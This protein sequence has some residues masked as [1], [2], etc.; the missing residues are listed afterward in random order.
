MYSG[1]LKRDLHVRL[2]GEIVDLVRLRLLHNADEIGRIGGIAVMHEER[3]ARLVRIMV[4][5]IDA[6][7]IE[8]RRTALDAVHDIALGEQEFGEIGAVLAGDAGDQRAL[9]GRLR[10]RVHRSLQ[11]CLFHDEHHAKR[12]GSADHRLDRAFEPQASR[13]ASASEMRLHGLKPPVNG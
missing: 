8:R 2:G 5:V 3:D 13:R 7:G 9:L 1:D 10:H 6:P 4:Q 12:Y 11:R